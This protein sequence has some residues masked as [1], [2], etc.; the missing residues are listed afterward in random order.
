MEINAQQDI[1]E[2]TYFPTESHLYYGKNS[3][4]EASNIERFFTE[5]KEWS[6]IYRNGVMVNEDYNAIFV[7]HFKEAYSDI[8]QSSKFISLPMDVTV[9]RYDCDLTPYIH[10]MNELYDNVLP[11]AITSF[12]PVL[13]SNEEVVYISGRAADLLRDFIEE[14][15]HKTIEKDGRDIKVEKE[16]EEIS[17]EDWA[18]RK[19]RVFM[20]R[21]YVPANRSHWGEL[22]Y[23]LSYPQITSFIVGNDGYFISIDYMTYYGIRY[24]VPWQGE[25]EEIGRWIQ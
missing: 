15:M 10:N 4:A 16:Y 12:T 21:E 24:Y 13:D 25:P 11:L 23:F 14:P 3:Y 1:R 19:K 6:M 17:E 7:K 2:I 18:E 22:W 9:T 5:L 20:I 8:E